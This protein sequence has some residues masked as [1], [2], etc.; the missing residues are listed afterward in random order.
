MVNLQDYIL[1]SELFKT[2]EVDELLFVEYRCL[3]NDHQ[4]DIWTHHNYLA[5]VLGGEKKWKSRQNEYRV[6]SGEALFVRKGATTVYQ[7]FDEPFYVLFL[8]LPDRFIRE[9]LSKHPPLLQHKR[10]HPRSASLIPVQVNPVLDAYFQSLFAYFSQP[11]PLFKDL[12]RL[13][14]EELILHI[15]TQPGNSALSNC[16]FELTRQEKVNLKETMLTHFHLPLSIEDYARLCARSLSSFRRDFKQVFGL[17]P[18][19]WLTEKRLEY[20]RFLLETTDKSITE[21]VAE[22]GFKND[23]HFSKIFKRRFG[24]SPKK[25]R[26]AY[27][28]DSL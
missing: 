10:A 16:F 17:T 8:F 26:L 19:R 25:F 2:F 13:K 22:S 1:K 21:I 7:Y 9:V 18:G 28:T 5:Y 14:L 4:S 3:I 24:H 11:K 27:R 12:L 15:C 6:G 20:S 23:A